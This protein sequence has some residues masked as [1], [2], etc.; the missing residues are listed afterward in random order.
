M[1]LRANEA[2]NSLVDF[3]TKTVTYTKQ[4][5]NYEGECMQNCDTKESNKKKRRKEIHLRAR[6]KKHFLKEAAKMKGGDIFEE[7]DII[8]WY[9]DMVNGGW[10]TVTQLSPLGEVR[11]FGGWGKKGKLINGFV[12]RMANGGHE[13]VEQSLMRIQHP[14]PCIAKQGLHYTAK[15][16]IATQLTGACFGGC[17]I[18]VKWATSEEQWLYTHQVEQMTKQKKR[19]AK[20][21]DRFSP[22]KKGEGGSTSFRMGRSKIARKND[23]EKHYLVASEKL[24]G[25]QNC[26]ISQA[27][28]TAFPNECE[29]DNG[30]CSEKR[31][32]NSRKNNDLCQSL[33]GLSLTYEV[34]RGNMPGIISEA[35]D[36]AL[37]V[38]RHKDM[39][40]VSL[41]GNI[42]MDK[43]GKG[44]DV[45]MNAIACAVDGKY[46]NSRNLASIHKWNRRKRQ[47]MFQ[48]CSNNAHLTDGEYCLRHTQRKR[49]FCITCKFNTV[50]R[51]GGL[52][53]SCFESQPNERKCHI[54][55]VRSSRRANGCCSACLESLDRRVRRRV[56]NK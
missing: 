12:G 41:G 49:T 53:T 21:I 22:G 10:T 43:E 9:G 35:V 55:K 44:C 38:N 15:G 4:E 24:R 42:H 54:C 27:M 26:T 56:F 29:V 39:G 20:P 45:Y 33:I 51:K 23:F 36:I 37:G 46:I 2:A 19:Q 31:G 13:P 34:L 16:T 40:D 17:R 14:P 11:D 7:R 32:G 25:N 6:R 50:K 3:Q 48:Q 8:V 18:R 30:M 5:N 1:H 47:C 28:T 52:C